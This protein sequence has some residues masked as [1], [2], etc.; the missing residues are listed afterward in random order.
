MTFRIAVLP[1]DE[2]ACGY[3]RMRLPAGAVKLARPDWTVEVYRPSEVFL[4]AGYDGELWNIKGIPDVQNVDLM[5]MQ[6]VGTSLQQKLVEWALKFGIA[7][8]VDSDDAMW[9]I[10]KANT[11][12]PAWNNETTSWRWLDRASLYA[13][14]TTVTTKALLDR[15]GKHGRS[16]VIP[17]CIPGDLADLLEP[18]R[19]SFD[20][21]TTIGWAGFTGTHPGDLTV[22]GDAVSRA[23]ADTGCLV[24]VIGDAA[25]AATDWGIKEVNQIEPVPIGLPYYTALT[26]LD[27]GL[28]PLRDTPFNKA[29]SYLKALE[30]AASGVAVIASPTPANRELAKTVPIIL[31]SNPREWYEAITQLIN[32]PGRRED[33][34]ERGREAV[35]KHHTYEANAEHWA[36]VWE[37]AI[38]RRARMVEA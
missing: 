1:A 11:A 23:V 27:I 19:E 7:V 17:N 5:V 3:Y 18:I 6:R 4:G 33:L 38:V 30:F 22:V 21:T 16:K 2:S 12:W 14:L 8:V 37:R 31:A 26:T 10:D 34:V 32:Q 25:G 15:Y 36:E 13:D 28:V 24:R 29:K 20:P 35:Y 9:A